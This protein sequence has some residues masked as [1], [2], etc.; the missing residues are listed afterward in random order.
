MFGSALPTSVRYLIVGATS[1]FFDFAVYQITLWV[2][3]SLHNHLPVYPEKLAN[4]CGMLVGFLMSFTLNK[5]WSFNAKDHA[6]RQ[7]FQSV[8]LLAFNTLIG[9]F[10]ITFFIRE[11]QMQSSIAKIL[12]QAVLVSWNYYI[13]KHIIYRRSHGE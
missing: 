4:T 7:F 9:A 1:A 8:L 10:L 13:F 2:F 5:Y 3:S 11:L 12:L 6:M